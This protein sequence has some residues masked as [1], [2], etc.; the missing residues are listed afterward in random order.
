MPDHKRAG[1]MGEQDVID[2]VECPNCGKRLMTLPQG[3][4]MYDVQCTACVFR[5]QVKTSYSKP[6]D[7][8]RGAGWEIMNK[9]LKAGYMVPPLIVNFKW[10]EGQVE[11]QEIYFYPFIP[12]ANLRPHKISIKAK[13]A[14][15]KMFNY[16]GLQRLPRRRLYPAEDA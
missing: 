14:G 12:K 3:Y 16:A 10:K 11:K 9:V 8:I 15:Y 1:D 7:V 2:L 13:R 4:P 6:K 5:A